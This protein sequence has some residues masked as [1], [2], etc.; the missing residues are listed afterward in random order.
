MRAGP[1][2]RRVTIQ[3]SI[4]VEDD[5]GSGVEEW[6][7]LFTTWASATQEGGREFFAAATVQA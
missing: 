1:L 4:L 5:Y 2:Y 7:D 3:R 6:S